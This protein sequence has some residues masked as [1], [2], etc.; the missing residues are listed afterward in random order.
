MCK[1]LWV[2]GSWNPTLRLR[3]VQAVSKST[4]RGAPGCSRNDFATMADS[5]PPANKRAT[6]TSISLLSALMSRIVAPLPA[7]RRSFRVLISN[8]IS[9]HVFPCNSPFGPAARPSCN[10]ERPGRNSISR[11]KHFISATIRP[12]G[13]LLHW[14]R[15]SST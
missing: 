15:T 5:R 3:S 8:Q 1:S 4:K 12:L 6:A 10:D 11:E 14:Q 2:R 9:R 13:G 7:T